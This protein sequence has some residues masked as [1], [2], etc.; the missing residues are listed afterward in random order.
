MFRMN[1]QLFSDEQPVQRTYTEEEVVA[2]LAKVHEEKAIL[3]AE[4]KRRL[5]RDK[6]VPAVDIEEALESIEGESEAEIR[7]SIDALGDTLPVL[8]R[9]NQL[10]KPRGVDPNLGNPPRQAPKPGDL[11]SVGR[12]AFERL[13]KAGKF[14]RFTT[15]KTEGYTPAPVESVQRRWR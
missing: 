14:N 5:L 1:L 15:Q 2:A 4:A 8:I 11:T 12:E 13:K 6:G 9:V 10:T 3:I 7:A